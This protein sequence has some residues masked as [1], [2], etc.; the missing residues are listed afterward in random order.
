MATDE[1]QTATDWM[2]MYWGDYLR[3]TAHLSAAEHGAYLL[4]I[5]HYWSTWAPLPDDDDK[6]RRIARMERAEWKRARPVL[7]EFFVIGDGVWRH[8]RV[9]REMEKASAKRERFAKR[10]KDAAEA[11][12]ARDKQTDGDCN[13]DATS[14]ATSTPRAVL[15]Q[16]PP[17]PPQKEK[18]K[19]GESADRPVGVAPPEPPPE[20]PD[21]AWCWSAETIDY[22]RVGSTDTEAS[23]RG[24]VGT[25][26]QRFGAD[27]TADVIR[28]C[29]A[30]TAN[31]PLAWVNRALANRA[32]ERKAGR[33]PY[34]PRQPAEPM[35][36]MGAVVR[37]NREAEVG[38]G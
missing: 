16:C 18:N 19:G 23:V 34:S 26:I 33:A 5:G 2:P 22:L 36:L 32:A 28:Q 38:H 4:M 6:L 7:V 24:M 17:P 12:W 15:G 29:Q 25:W 20:D 14:N 30:S 35:G 10:A 11:R 31:K 8:P 1:R 9:E 27:E 13:G 37:M 21:V 3:D